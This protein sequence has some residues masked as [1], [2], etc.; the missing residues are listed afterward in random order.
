VFPDGAGSSARLPV[1]FTS[2]KE[3]RMYWLDRDALGG[4]QDGTDLKALASLPV[5]AQ[6]TFGSSAYFNG[7]IYVAAEKSPTFAF[8]INNATLAASPAQTPDA[9]SNLGAT[10]RTSANGAK[11]GIVWINA[12]SPGGR[13]AVSRSPTRRL[14]PLPPSARRS[15]RTARS[16]SP[17]IMAWQCTAK[18]RL[19]R[20]W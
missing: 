15:L 19:P 14:T 13:L 18:W 12:S 11:N 9:L 5:L 20:L 17:A 1:L 7:S 8:R 4:P 2:G 6:A 16:W 10:P 3:G